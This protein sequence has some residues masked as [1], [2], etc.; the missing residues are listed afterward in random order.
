MISVIII[1]AINPSTIL[2]RES[3]MLATPSLIFSPIVLFGRKYVF[4]SS[5]V[6]D[7]ISAPPVAIFIRSKIITQTA[8]NSHGICMKN[9]GGCFV[10]NYQ[11]TKHPPLFFIQMQDC[12]EQNAETLASRSSGATTRRSHGARS[13]ARSGGVETGACC[14]AKR[15]NNVGRNAEHPRNAEHQRAPKDSL[16]RRSHGARSL[17]QRSRGDRSE[18]RRAERRAERRASRQ[19]SAEWRASRQRIV[20][21]ERPI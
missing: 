13:L 16:T 11:I 4:V 8:E 20:K 1:V 9:N 14:G 7:F 5:P 21:A 6:I 18:A 15:R 17:A 19:R 3:T 2:H 12:S 10:I